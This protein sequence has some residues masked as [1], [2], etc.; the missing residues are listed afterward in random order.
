MFN[1]VLHTPT[2]LVFFCHIVVSVSAVSH[3]CVHVYPNVA[4]IQWRWLRPVLQQP[5]VGALVGDVDLPTAVLVLPFVDSECEGLRSVERRSCHWK[6]MCVCL[7]HCL[8]VDPAAK[9][10]PK[11]C[12]LQKNT[13]FAKKAGFNRCLSV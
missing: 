5:L 9:A 7:L 8:L 3:W 10:F 11:C 12:V 6:P 13:V 1:T 2:L 4:D